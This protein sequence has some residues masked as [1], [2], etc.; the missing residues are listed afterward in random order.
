[1]LS[2]TYPRIVG[3]G[4]WGGDGDNNFHVLTFKALNNLCPSYISDL[5]ETY[6]PTRSLRSWSRNLLVIP[7]SKLKSYGDRAFSVCAPKLWN[8]IPEIIKCS[9]NLNTFKHNLKTCLVKRYFNE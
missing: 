8:G 2:T 4:V 7:R 9:V 1:M 5:L 3:S 6:K